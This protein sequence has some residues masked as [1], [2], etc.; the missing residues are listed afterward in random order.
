MLGE[1]L[2][3]RNDYWTSANR[4]HPGANGKY[5]VSLFEDLREKS[6][7]LSWR[8]RIDNAIHSKMESRGYRLVV[9]P[10]L[11]AHNYGKLAN[12]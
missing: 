8:K 6:M 7:A 10:T 11:V 12:F 9:A 2:Q 4:H 3:I 5:K 1:G